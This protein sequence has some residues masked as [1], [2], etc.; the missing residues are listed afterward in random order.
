MEPFLKT[1]DSVVFDLDGTLWDTMNACAIAWN[2]VI[3][4]HQFPFRNIL[5]DNIRQ[6]T[7]L[8]HEQCIRRVF[9][10]LPEEKIRVLIQETMEEDNRVISEKGGDLYPG[11]EE[12]LT[13]LK[14]RFPLFIVSNCQTGYIETFLKWSKFSFFQD[15]ECWGN[16]G[17]SKAENLKKLIA[18]NRLAS[19]IFVGDT[20]GDQSAAQA[21]QVPFVHVEYGFG[22]CVEKDLAVGSFEELTQKLLRV[23]R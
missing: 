2:R 8:P 6:V 15:F 13:K 16:T 19:P 12:G 23:D 17:L 9:E 7:G 11:V 3:E 4:R 20:V 14:D 5:P 18:R 22:K 21:C 1:L 10:G